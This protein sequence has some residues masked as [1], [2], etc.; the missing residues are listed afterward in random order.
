[1]AQLGG[2]A[3]TSQYGGKYTGDILHPYAPLSGVEVAGIQSQE[4]ANKIAL[5][6]WEFQKQMY[7]DQM[8]AAKAGSGSFSKLVNQYNR[9]Y[10]DARVANEN[11]YNEM[12]GITDATTGQRMAD[13]RQDYM[14]QQSDMMQQLARL[15]MG[16]TTIGSNLGTGIQRGMQ[17]SLNRAADTL[18]GT[19]LGIMERRTDAYPDNSIILALANQMG[20]SFGGAG[21]NPASMQA[22]GQMRVGGGTA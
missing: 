1:M 3:S 21:M 6:Q 7:K 5:D 8:A 4:Q 15:G 22:L 14:G 12:L 17:E 20:Q 10:E 2:I 18:Q 19:K 16:S 13:I 9:A 11:R